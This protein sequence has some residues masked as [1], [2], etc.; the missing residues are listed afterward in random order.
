MSRDAIKL[1]QG[2]LAA[3][4]ANIRVDGIIGV[5]T[6]EAY[7]TAQSS[8]RSLIEETVYREEKVKFSE[9]LD[10][11]RPSVATMRSKGRRASK[12][13]VA[14]LRELSARSKG[15][16]AESVAAESAAMSLRYSKGRRPVVDGRSVYR[17]DEADAIALARKFNGLAGLPPGT[18]EFI[19]SMEAKRVAGGFDAGA[20]GGAGNM[21]C[22][23]YQFHRSAHLSWADGMRWARRF[24]F[25]VAPMHPNGWKSAEH[26]TACAAG[27]AMM[28]ASILAERRY[29]VTRETLYAAHQQGAGGAIKMANRT[30]F[31]YVGRQSSESVRHL[32]TAYSQMTGKLEA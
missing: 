12:P 7:D 21:Y 23:L 4:G 17:I 26:N 24:G 2:Q 10:A 1:A 11:V 20:V 14:E 28:N 19:L 32:K 5:E 3:S 22:G 25:R 16:R 9:L 29:P 8:T 27:Y 13:T 18:M 6:I 15:R 31:G 30:Q